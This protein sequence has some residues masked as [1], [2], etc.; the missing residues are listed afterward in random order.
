M[1]Q[2]LKLYSLYEFALPQNVRD[3][4]EQ[5][6]GDIVLTDNGKGKQEVEMFLDVDNHPSLKAYME[7][8]RMLNTRVLC[9]GIVDK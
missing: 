5:E 3:D 8:M 1:T 6:L 4:V 2:K 7:D 9:V